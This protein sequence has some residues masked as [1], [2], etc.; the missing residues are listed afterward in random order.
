MQFNFYLG[1]YIT[2]YVYKKTVYCTIVFKRDL[3]QV[4]DAVNNVIRET[5]PSRL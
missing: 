3:Q 2:V 4:E 1:I 5:R